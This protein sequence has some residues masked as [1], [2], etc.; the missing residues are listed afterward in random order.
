MNRK[1]TNDNNKSSAKRRKLNDQRNETTVKAAASNQQQSAHIVKFPIEILEYIFDYLQLR[2]LCAMSATCKCM[3]QAAGQ[4]YRRKFLSL[5]PRL[6]EKPSGRIDIQY[7][8]VHS[9][10]MNILIEFIDTIQIDQRGKETILQKYIDRQLEFHQNRNLTLFNFNLNKTRIDSMEAILGKLEHLRVSYCKMNENT[11]E[12]I[13]ALAPNIKRLSLDGIGAGHNKWFA[14][15]Y[16]KL[17]R[18]EITSRFSVPIARFLKLNPNIRKF[19]IDSKNLW[20]NRQLIKT[21]KIK[22]DN[23]TVRIDENNAL[24][25]RFNLLNQ[26]HKIGFYKRLTCHFCF[27]KR[28]K[29]N[30]KT[31]DEMAKLNAFHKLDVC[32]FRGFKFVKL[33]ALNHLEEINLECSVQILDIE[34]MA[35]SFVNL[36]RIKFRNSTLSHVSLFIRQNPKLQKMIV[37]RILDVNFRKQDELILDL[38]RLNKTRTRLLNAMKTTLYV[39]ESVYLATKWATRDTNLDLLQLKRIESSEWDNGFYSIA[40]EIYIGMNTQEFLL[41]YKYKLKNLV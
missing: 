11:L 31:V 18:C 29:F 40:D 6:V 34:A 17:E 32:E 21:A 33:S 12:K 30:Q 14:N 39:S 35:T 22:L 16:P 37:N 15:K 4:F 38:Y 8:Y 2:D 25:S 10:N 24:R 7:N 1:R 27:S 19:G 20:E 9:F 5:S 26:L 28:K 23:L 41:N 3:Q 36:N 13:L